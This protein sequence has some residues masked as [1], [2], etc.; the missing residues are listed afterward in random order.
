MKIAYLSASTVPSKDANSVHVMKMSQAFAKDG[1]DVILYARQSTEK[2]DDDY[3]Y[4]GVGNCFKIKKLSWPSLRFFGGFIYGRNVKKDIQKNEKADIYYGRDLYS[5]LNVS[6]I[7]GSQIYYEA[8]K[9]PATYVHKILERRLFSFKN[10]K[11]LV[12]IS[13]ALRKEYLRIFPELK[14]EKIV[15]AHDGADLPE[16]KI[17][18]SAVNK[19]KEQVKIG[20]VGHLYQGKGMEL[21]AELAKSI[22]NM[23]FHIIGGKESDIAYWKK[24]VNK[25]N[26]IFHGFVSHGMLGEYFDQLDIVLAPYQTK[27]ATSGGGGDISKWMSPLK[28]FEY[29]ANGKAIVSSDLPVLREI[30]V[31]NINSILCPPEDVQAWKEAIIL[32]ASDKSKLIK[33]GDN[34]RNDFIKQYTWLQRGR[35]VIA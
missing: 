15:V 31:N 13:D 8:H 12:V 25:E 22:P 34:A 1:H 11:R 10:F 4:Y 17:N 7:K 26:I 2:V 29:M 24:H 3:Y 30:L 9:P 20:Y 32:L 27:V 5:L 6:S 14:S 21:I 35:N 19:G 28:I 33:L 23:E 18:K 16:P